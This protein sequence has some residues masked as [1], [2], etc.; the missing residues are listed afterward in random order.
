MDVPGLH[1]N[2]PRDIAPLV[3]HD[4][5][6]VVLQLGQMELLLAKERQQLSDV[7]E[8][9]LGGVVVRGH[10]LLDNDP[11]DIAVVHGP[12]HARLG[13]HVLELE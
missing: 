13:L 6:D 9:V 3:D 7:H 1:R 4:H 11:I 10:H 8:R 5:G 2:L 12:A